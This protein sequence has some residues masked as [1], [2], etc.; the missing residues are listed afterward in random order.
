MREL[1][2]GYGL[3]TDWRSKISPIEKSVC[4]PHLGYTPANNFNV[5]ESWADIWQKESAVVRLEPDATGQMRISAGAL[6]HSAIRTMCG[7]LSVLFIY[8]LPRNDTF[9]PPFRRS[10]DAVSKKC[11]D[12][13]WSVTQTESICIIGKS[14][15]E[16]SRR[17]RRSRILFL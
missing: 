8:S 5:L 3:N 10:G 6:D 11:P 2:Q 7:T 13:R 15:T 16:H 1:P 9:K 4:S 14:H 12:K 17:S